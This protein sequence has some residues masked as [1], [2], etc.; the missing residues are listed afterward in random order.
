MIGIGAAMTAGAKTV[1]TFVR[2]ARPNSVDSVW[3][4]RHISVFLRQQVLQ[5]CIDFSLTE[6]LNISFQNKWLHSYTEIEAYYIQFCNKKS[7]RGRVGAGQ[8]CSVRQQQ[9]LAT[10]TSIAIYLFEV[11]YSCS[12]S[13]FHDSIQSN[14]Y[15]TSLSHLPMKTVQLLYSYLPALQY[16]KLLHISVRNINAQTVCSKCCQ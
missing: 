15:W 5:H 13:A 14:F 2:R 9:L 4:L 1:Y 6:Y 3:H 7:Q 8:Q 11:M 12:C 16:T 10:T